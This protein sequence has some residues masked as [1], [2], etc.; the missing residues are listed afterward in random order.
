MMSEAKEKLINEGY[1]SLSKLLISLAT[2][3]IVFSV[4]LIKPI[5]E[6]WEK[7]FLVFGLVLL[8][9]SVALG[10]TYVRLKLDSLSCHDKN[11]GL[12]KRV[13]GYALW[14]QISFY[15]GLLLVTVAGINSLYNR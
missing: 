8:V 6:N 13:D 5:A 9:C 1:T 14:Q 11:P 3:T 15:A 4:N 10:V 7:Y 2:G 12:I